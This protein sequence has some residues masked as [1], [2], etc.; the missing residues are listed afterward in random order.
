MDK[1]YHV[2]SGVDGWIIRGASGFK[3]YKNK[4][5]AVLAAKEM[6]S[7]KKLPIVIHSKD[8]RVSSVSYGANSKKVQSANVKRRL[9]VKLVRNSIAEVSYERNQK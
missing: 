4:K 8:G 5:N 1:K 9:N 2:L 3:V 6:A 7:K